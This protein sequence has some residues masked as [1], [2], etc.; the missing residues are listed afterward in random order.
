MSLVVV[1]GEGTYYCIPTLGYHD[2]DARVSSSPRLHD[3]LARFWKPSEPAPYCRLGSKY[4]P[5]IS[6]SNWCEG[7][8]ERVHDTTPSAKYSTSFKRNSLA[9]KA[10][11]RFWISGSSH[12]PRTLPS[13]RCYERHS[14]GKGRRHRLVERQ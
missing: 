13:K 9:K 2:V 12:V 8:R 3:P 11:V 10:R 14:G 5:R 6:P 1:V 7:H 4:L